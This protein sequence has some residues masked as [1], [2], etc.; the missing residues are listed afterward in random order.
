MAMAKTLPVSTISSTD[1]VAQILGHLDKSYSIDDT[2]QLDLD[3]ANFLEFTWHKSATVEQFI[4]G[5]HTRLHK[6]SSLNIDDKLKGHLLLRQANLDPMDKS[7]IVGAASGKYDVNSISGALRQAYRSNPP[8]GTNMRTTP[9][10]WTCKRLG[11]KCNRCLSKQN[12]P[13]NNSSSA[14]NTSQQS[15]ADRITFHTFANYFIFQ[16]METHAP[17]LTQGLVHP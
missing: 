1:G 7:M 14:D 8:S 4:A 5:F 11:K 9:S 15:T 2:D 13:G 3:L 17:F 6:I 16:K 10:C 12:N